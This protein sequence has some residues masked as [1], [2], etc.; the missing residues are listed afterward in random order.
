MAPRFIGPLSVDQFDPQKIIEINF[1][2]C[3]IHSSMII[4]SEENQEYIVCCGAKHQMSYN[5]ISCRG[6]K[7]FVPMKV[8]YLPDELLVENHGT[9][10]LI[11][12]CPFNRD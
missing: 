5:E 9:F 1:W 7:T 3:L 11:K 2:I 6:S 4:A 12:S 10:D 8:K